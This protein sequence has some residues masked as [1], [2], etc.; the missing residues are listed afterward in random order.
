MVNIR[1]IDATNDDV[2]EQMRVMK[3]GRE[4]GRYD[5]VICI[6]RG[7]DDDPREL[8]DI[9]EVRAFCRRIVNLAFISYLDFATTVLTDVPDL[10]KKG[11]GAAEV[12]LCGE[13][14]FKTGAEWTMELVSEIAQAVGESN[15][16]AD[17][18]LGPME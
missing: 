4:E 9:P 11:W 6:I 5:N 7:F 13:G 3:R 1:K 15:E 2:I 17:G 16:K 8:Y 12:W 14:R 18:L 10:V